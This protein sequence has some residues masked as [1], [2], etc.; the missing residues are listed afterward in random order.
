M[1][2]NSFMIN[3]FTQLL[4]MSFLLSNE[5]LNMN[6]ISNLTFDE[7]LSDITGFAQDGREIAV[8]GLENSTALVDVTDPTSPY[9][10]VRI[11]GGTSSWRDIKYWNRHLYIGTEAITNNGIQIISVDNIDNPVLVNVMDDFG[12]SHN[13]WIDDDGFLYVLGVLQDCDIWIY[14]L[15]NPE[16]PEQVGCWQ[17]DYIHDIDVF[18]NKLYAAA[19]N[20]STI[21]VLDVEEKNNIYVLASWSYPG[22]AHDC[23][24]TSDSRFLVTADEMLGG[25]LKIWNI[26]DF[27]NIELVGEYVANLNHSIHNVYVKNNL[28]FCSYYADG[29]RVIDISNPSLPVEVAFYDTSNLEGLYV[30]NWGVY[31]FLPSN[32]II[33]SDI[34]SGLFVLE[35]NGIGIEHSEFNEQSNLD[36]FYQ[37]EFDLIELNSSVNDAKIFYRNFII[38]NQWTNINLNSNNFNSYYANIPKH[39][40]GSVIQYYVEVTDHNEIKY[41]YNNHNS[42]NPM[43]FTVGQLPTII[44]ENFEEFTSSSNWTLSNNSTAESGNWERGIPNGTQINSYIVQPFTDYTENGYYCFLTGNIISNNPYLDDVDSGST[45]LE[46]PVYNLND[47]NNIIFSF[48]YWFSNSLG[49]SPQQDYFSVDISNDL[50]ENWINLKNT[51]FP[52]NNWQESKIVISDQ[53][54]MTDEMIFRFTVSDF[55]DSSLV[56]AAIDDIKIQA[57]GF[58]YDYGDVNFDNKIDII[59]IVSI[60]G[61]IQSNFLFNLFQQLNADFN[62]DNIINVLDIVTIVEFILSE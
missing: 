27:N 62:Q 48:A 19:I 60:L 33:S 46:S 22:E 49:D 6:L 23:S 8:V 14:T 52:T 13:L 4:F 37:V 45:I 39:N 2:L 17:G 41:Y 1:L 21:Y 54:N 3:L 9:E 36:E 42:D 31:P 59:D 35:L 51:N 43:F 26:E 16:S 50:G 34:E 7:E 38:E 47:Y 12:T 5:S 53:I 29:T 61:Y 30:G 32:N 44:D 55:G 58:P 24:I 11:N 10:I 18:D 56:E 25:H 15:Q 57:F 20:S 40:N 28:V